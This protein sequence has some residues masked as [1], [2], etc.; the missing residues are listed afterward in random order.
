MGMVA[1]NWSFYQRRAQATTGTIA[2]TA[3]T[4]VLFL[5]YRKACMEKMLS[6]TAPVMMACITNTNLCISWFVIN[7]LEYLLTD[8]ACFWTAWDIESLMCWFFYFSF[9]LWSLFDY[10][11][12]FCSQQYVVIRNVTS[13]LEICRW[14]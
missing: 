4:L 7:V 2:H 9:P 1:N 14:W 3:D 8:H 5:R 13:V 10:D 12:V 11:I 6:T